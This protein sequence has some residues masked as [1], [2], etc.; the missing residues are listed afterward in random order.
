MFTEKDLLQIKEKGMAVEQLSAQLQDFIR[1]FPFASLHRPAIAGDGI[2][3]YP[4]DEVRR[5][6]AFY[7]ER[8]PGLQIVKFVPASGA[9]TRMF[10]DLYA[11]I[12]AVRS[13]GNSEIALTDNAEF[14]SVKEFFDNIK[15]FA[16][17]E[18][19]NKACSH[20]GFS[21]EKAVG[22][23]N[24]SRILETLLEDEGLGYGKLPKGLLK[25]HSYPSGSATAIEEHLAEAAMYARNS[26]NVAEVHFTVSPEHLSGFEKKVD[27]AL[28][29]YERRFGIRFRISY[30][31][32]K[33]STD[34]LAVD[35]ENKPFRNSDG[36][37]L[38]RPGGHGALIE[39]LNDIDADLIFIKNIDNVVP[40]YLK[41]TTV[42]YKKALAA[43]VLQIQ[44][45]V[46]FFLQHLDKNDNWEM[47]KPEM[48]G[49]VTNTM[50]IKLPPDMEN[51]S[52]AEQRSILFHALNRPIRVCGMVKN[53]GEPGGGPFWVNAPDGQISPQIVESSQ[54]NEKDPVQ[55][56]IMNSSSHFNP[57]DLVCATRDFKGRPFDLHHF[58]DPST[59]FISVKSKDG[60]PLK[61]MELPG[62]WNGAMARWTTVFVEVPV[63]TFN[64]VKTVND[65]LRQQHQPE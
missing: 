22:S 2:S 53:E 41:D 61:A 64:P 1:G 34:T 39:N 12:P 35:M 38:F 21:L 28:P 59:G 65:L 50:N 19:L 43:I 52:A 54:I 44:E 36:S 37:L 56:G 9:A 14:R 49:F 26:A 42:L 33:P 47:H 46:F 8:L 11:F 63:I 13:T 17:Y 27:E 10:K 5:L 20:A 16:F 57:V 7:E 25:F 62:L 24:Y 45:K 51:R 32:Q 30:S 29:V 40:D 58:I 23:G 15:A 60:K 3:V 48:V 6:S 55:K 31:Q 4:E 18:D